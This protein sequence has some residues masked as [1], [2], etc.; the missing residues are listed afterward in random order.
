[1]EVNAHLMRASG[2]KT[3][4]HQRELAERFDHA[5]MSHGMLALA[6]SRAAAAAAVAAIRHQVRLNPLVARVPA[7]ERQVGPFNR[8]RAEL[9]AEMAFRFRRARQDDQAA[10]FFVEAMHGP[11]PCPPAR[12]MR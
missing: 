5:N 7:P 9:L 2:F 4:L 1:A 10:R 8:M 12:R 6:R 11:D 3:A